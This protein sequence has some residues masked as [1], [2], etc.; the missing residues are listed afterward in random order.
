MSFFD[1]KNFSLVIAIVIGTSFAHAD[2]NGQNVIYLGSGS[3]KSGN[4]SVTSNKTPVTLGYL[5]L[6][7]TTDTVWGAD[8][9]GEGTMLDS[10]WGQNRAVK[11]AT[12]FNILL[13]KNLGKTEN[14]RF[15]A[16]LI[17]GAREKTRSC[18]ASYLGYQC[19]ADTKPNTSYGFNS[20]VALTWAYKSV[21]LGLRA[22]G[23][24]TQILLGYRY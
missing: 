5:R 18:P 13:G 10:S 11:Q 12:S 9:S 17:L 15:D 6:S 3:A 22:T 4:P 7:N 2:E 20:G 1:F 8:I 19:Y 14:S 16:S 21:L 24:S 23:E